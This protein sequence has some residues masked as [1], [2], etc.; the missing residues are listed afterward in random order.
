MKNIIAIFTLVFSL[1]SMAQQETKGQFKTTIEKQAELNYLLYQPKDTTVA[2]PLILFLHGSGE[3]GN[4]LEKIK[5]YGPFKYLKTNSLDAF[6]LAPQCPEGKNWDSDELYAL[7]Q[8]VMKEHNIDSSRVSLTGL[9]HGGWGSWNLAAAYPDTFAVLVPICGMVDR[10]PLFE[11]EKIKNIPTRIF[12]GV[13]DD[14]VPMT[15]SVTI[16]RK[17]VSIQAKD[18]HLTLFDD[19]NHDSWTRVYDNAEIYEWMLQQKKEVKK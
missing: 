6:V 4:D 7:V 11:A 3:K 13:L 12:H 14:V 2:K 5:V 1:F 16:Y 17:L 15:E 19:A 9:S 10:V 8:K 18:V